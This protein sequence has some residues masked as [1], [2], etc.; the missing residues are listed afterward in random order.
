MLD[1]PTPQ[2]RKKSNSLVRF[3]YTSGRACVKVCSHTRVKDLNSVLIYKRVTASTQWSCTNLQRSYTSITPG[4]HTQALHTV[5]II[6]C[7][8]R[9][10]TA[11]TPVF[12]TSV[13]PGVHTQALHTIKCYGRLWT[14]VTLVSIYKQYVWCSYSSITPSV[15]MQVWYPVRAV[16]IVGQRAT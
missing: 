3:A 4:A 12:H 1:D 16:I 14:G 6:K 11:L 9:L 2:A 7:N 13:T 8:S 10:C 15:H 5:F